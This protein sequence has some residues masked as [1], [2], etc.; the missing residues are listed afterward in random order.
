MSCRRAVTGKKG[1]MSFFNIVVNHVFFAPRQRH[2]ISLS[3]G[4]WGLNQFKKGVSAAIATALAVA[5]RLI[6]EFMKQ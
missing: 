2:S 3:T 1:K 4:F 6:R 5:G